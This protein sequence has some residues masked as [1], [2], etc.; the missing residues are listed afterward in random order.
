MEVTTF[1]G[2]ASELAALR[3]LLD[4]VSAGREQVA[5]V[6]GEAGIGKT[7]LVEEIAADA[8]D[9]GFEVFFG[10]AEELEHTRPYGALADALA[11]TKSSPDAARAE[12]AR[13]LGEDQEAGEPDLGVQYRALDAFV[14]L[15]EATAMRAPLALVLED[16]HWADASTL[17]AFRAI[18]RRLTFLPIALIG[19][20]RPSPRSPE[21]ERMEEAFAPDG[22]L[23]LSVG[24]LDDDAI[25]GLLTESTG[26][27][28]GGRL[29]T[30]VAG[31]A[32]N[33]LFVTELVKALEQEGAIETIDGRAEVR[34]ISLPPTLRLTIL[35]RLSFLPEDALEVLQIAAIL[36]VAFSPSDLATVMD[37]PAVALLPSLRE[38]LRAGILEEHGSALRFRHEL[39]RNAIY[40]DMPEGIRAG[41][42]REAA[43]ALAGA[44]A[45][46]LRVAQHFA[47]AASPGDIEAV[48]WLRNA[49]RDAAA[50]APAAGIE[51]LQRALELLPASD[52][53]RG[54]IQAE[55]ATLMA[56]S[57]RA[58]EGEMLARE[59]LSGEHADDLE[60]PVRFTLVQ[61]L[62]YQGRWSEEVAE[63]EAGSRHP[64]VDR[65]DR[66]RLLAECT[67]ARL[68]C[69]DPEGAWADGEE[70][71]RIGEAVKDD[72][73]LSLGLSH[74][75][76]IAGTRGDLLQSVTLAERGLAAVK[77]DEARRRDPYFPIAITLL[78]VDRFDDAE[79]RL[80]EGQRV[81]EKFGTA[82][83]LPVYHTLRAMR[84]WYQGEWDD[85]VAEAEAG[86]ALGKE[87]GSHPVA[88][89]AHCVLATIAVHRNDVNAAAKAV[90]AA[91]T[92]VGQVGIQ[93]GMNW[94]TRAQALLA[95]ARGDSEAA[96]QMLAGAWDVFAQLQ[97]A[98]IQL[99]IAPELAR[100]AVDHRDYERA[101]VVSEAIGTIARRA[102]VPTAEAA[103]LYCHGL[104]T[105]D[106]DALRRSIDAY[107]RSGRALE[108]ALACEA[109]AVALSR[110]AKTDDAEPL[111]R[112]ALALYERFAARRDVAR[113]TAAMRSFG[114][115]LGSRTPRGRPT[116]GWESLTPTELEVVR[117]AAQGLTNPQIGERLFISR[118]TV[119][120]HLSHVFGK[121]GL[122]SRVELA[123]EASQ[124]GR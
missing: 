62:M 77:T 96:L 17:L 39:I 18:G 44:G 86:L 20:Y 21:L 23:H 111:F 79:Q 113:V 11:C 27:P 1:W 50:G 89:A 92:I 59:I 109:T 71:V 83:S 26:R 74:M 48:G 120:T 32:G 55:L 3:D 78:D 118:A 52:P 64:H 36:G 30:E 72:L 49:A 117:L 34:E 46:R 4:R 104:A 82:W 43:R 69:G 16:L 37:R 7:K 41:L 97:V 25:V 105:D 100:L 6:E 90:E 98:H 121:L 40:D 63:A 51:L 54:A 57:G 61:T 22:R 124:H 8:E 106:E 85:A 122:G 94:L 13:L 58:R 67:L 84:R 73:A 87:I 31:A 35:R 65:R 60:G 81:A 101:H 42:H 47:L 75:S 76:A 66:G 10:R 38:A 123:A 45:S 99:F 24:P 119:A 15:V 2:R 9:R 53:A 70:A 114:I 103:A 93:W 91:E 5:F 12:I 102:G 116:V 115:R 33:P 88:L 110:H 107:R 108:P 95:E 19:S 28:P 80:L 14:D 112:E 68:F 29:L 56:F